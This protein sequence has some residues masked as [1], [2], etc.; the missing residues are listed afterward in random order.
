MKQGHHR[1]VLLNLQGKSQGYRW[2]K[3]GSETMLCSGRTRRENKDPSVSQE[4]RCPHRERGVI[5]ITIFMFV[6]LVAF[7]ATAYIASATQ[8]IQLAR[9]NE[10]SARLTQVAEGGINDLLLRLWK[11]LKTDQRYDSLDFLLTHASLEAPRAATSGSPNGRDAYAAGVIHYEAPDTYT[12]FVTVRSVAWEDANRNGRLENNEAYKIITAVVRLSLNR[13]QVFDYT[14]FVNNYGWWY[15][16]SPSM[17]II[18]GDMRANGNFHF[19]GGTPTVNGSIYAA[20]NNKLIPNAEGTINAAPVQWNLSTYESNSL[21]A[22]RRRPGY[23]SSVFGA[24]GS[25]LWEKYKDVI[26]DPTGQ[27]V[28]GKL[29]GSILA[30]RRGYRNYQGTILDVTP[31]R[32]LVMPDLSDLSRYIDISRNYV[33]QQAEFEDGT[34]NPNFGKGAYLEVYNAATNS[35]VR[36]DNN[37]VVNGSAILIGTTSRPIRIHGPVTFTQ[38]CVIKGVVEGQGTIYA[39]R[40]IHIVGSIK[41]KNPPD[42]RGNDPDR[43]DRENSSKDILALAA[44]R[45]IIMGNTAAFRFPYPLYYMTPP[46]TKPRYDEFG[47]LVPAYN[48]IE[49]DE[50]GRKRYQSVYGD[51]TIASLS[52]PISQLDC[53][54]YTNYLGGGQLGTGGG[55]VTF[56]GSIISKDEAMVIYSLP[57]V[58]NYDQRIRERRITNQ[59]LIDV[60]LPRTPEIVQATWQDHGLFTRG[61]S[62]GAS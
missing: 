54:L 47:N 15:G 20:P 35:Y 55:G 4:R 18:N 11:P 29:S 26:Y 56:N 14:Y 27:I 7:G 38:D 30:D 10:L 53:I 52:E 22:S 16:F 49:V 3:E 13:S 57:L 23:R 24:Y 41:Y 17:A 8:T 60:S 58:M 39:G 36:V 48:A 5:V 34:T 46:F 37:G 9:N 2:H 25:L 50:T 19:S 31:T 28:R 42:F 6:A 44:R 45:S 43:V 1:G 62:Y 51:P 59:P 40:N 12:R 32:E 61:R 21:Q 33:D